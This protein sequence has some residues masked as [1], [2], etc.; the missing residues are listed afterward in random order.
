MSAKKLYPSTTL[1]P[2]ANFE[3]SSE[4][5]INVINSFNTVINNIKLITN[6]K[7]ENRNSKQLSK[8]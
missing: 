4:K 1:Q 3:E 7:D 2:F 6:F 5:S 8:N